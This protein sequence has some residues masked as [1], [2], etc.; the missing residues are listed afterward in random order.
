MKAQQY[1]IALSLVVLVITGFRIGHHYAMEQDAKDA[2]IAARGGRV[3]PR[4]KTWG[5]T[6]SARP[7]ALSVECARDR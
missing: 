1:L 7:A 6:S 5:E 2:C 3:S 4:F